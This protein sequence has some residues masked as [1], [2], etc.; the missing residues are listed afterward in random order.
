MDTDS[1][2]AM[3]TADQPGTPA[4]FGYAADL[5]ARE[6][7]T[8]DEALSRELRPLTLAAVLAA[9]AQGAQLLDTRDPVEFAAAHLRGSINVGLGGQY[10]TWAGTVLTR[11]APIVLIAEPGAERESAMRLGRIGFDNVIGYLDGGL[12]SAEPRPDLIA[13]T[14]RL[15]P[16]VAAE[17]LASA[18]PPVLVDL[19]TPTERGKTSIPGSVHLPLSR[20]LEWIETLPKDRAVLLHCA[21]G[22]RSAIAASVL[23]RHG[24][25]QVSEMA[26]GIT[27][28]EQARLPL[29]RELGEGKSEI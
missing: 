25:E 13:S 28:W 20:L 17:R 27:A 8:L 12:R 21:G 2:V 9:E 23:R 22:Y 29:T 1:F 11:D 19:R 4:Y 7:Q 26:G 3:V 10:A 16:E 18:S 5:N 15:G 14:E 24:F 6:R